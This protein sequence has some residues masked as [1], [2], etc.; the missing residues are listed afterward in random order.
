M[1]KPNLI[2][3][4]DSTTILGNGLVLIGSAIWVMLPAYLPNNIA[5]LT[6]GGM[7]VD[8]GKNWS[9][10]KR[11]LGDGKTIRG[12]AGGDGQVARR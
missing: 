6:G 8:L 10:G 7:P 12:F 4:P 3:M 1:K 11:I 2:G 9:D 5:A